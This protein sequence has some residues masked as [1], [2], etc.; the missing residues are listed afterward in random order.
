MIRNHRFRPVPAN[1]I[2]PELQQN[3]G[4]VEYE[5]TERLAMR[6]GLHLRLLGL[7]AA[8]YSQ[9]FLAD[10]SASLE[11]SGVREIKIWLLR[12]RT[13]KAKMGARFTQKVSSYRT[14]DHSIT[15]RISSFLTFASNRTERKTWTN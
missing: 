14:P 13:V 5:R 10:Q 2:V 7:E 12:L 6:T 9:L 3:W 15:G 1:L 8:A 11:V 4:P